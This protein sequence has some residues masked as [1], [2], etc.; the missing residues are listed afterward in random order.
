[1]IKENFL[2][3]KEAKIVQ[4]GKDKKWKFQHRIFS[5][6]TPT[7]KKYTDLMLLYKSLNENQK[8]LQ[9]RLDALVQIRSFL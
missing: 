4:K 8:N 6:E 3:K 5:V 2:K 1:M 9:K 7:T